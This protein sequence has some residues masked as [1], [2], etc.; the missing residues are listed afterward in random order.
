MVTG[1]RDVKPVAPLASR[2]MTESEYQTTIRVERL[3]GH[4][5]VRQLTRKLA[6][7]LGLPADC[8]EPPAKPRPHRWVED[9]LLDQGYREAMAQMRLDAHYAIT[10]PR[11]GDPINLAITAA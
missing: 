4:I 2:G 9:R 3:F 7:D 10:L 1:R 6:T 11:P 8:M 5:Q